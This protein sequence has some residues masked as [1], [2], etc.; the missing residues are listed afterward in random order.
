MPNVTIW[1]RSDARS[2]A[3]ST[4][5]LIIDAVVERRLRRACDFAA[6]LECLSANE[7]VDVGDDL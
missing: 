4:L 2:G 7:G 6:S 5:L 1:K 3:W